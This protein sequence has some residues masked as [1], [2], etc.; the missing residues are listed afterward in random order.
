M[1][2]AR[3]LFRFLALAVRSMNMALVRLEISLGRTALLQ[4]EDLKVRIKMKM[5]SNKTQGRLRCLFGSFFNAP[6]AI[7]L[8]RQRVCSDCSL[9]IFLQLRPKGWQNENYLSEREFILYQQFTLFCLRI[10]HFVSNDIC[11]ILTYS[12]TRKLDR[13][14][15]RLIEDKGGRKK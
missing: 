4:G 14:S 3:I 9:P 10:Y 15:R 2:G 1:C 8:W 13:T 5:V 6:K 12:E 7:N 11:M